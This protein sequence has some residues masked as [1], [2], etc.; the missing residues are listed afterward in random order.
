[1][2][3]IQLAACFGTAL[4]LFKILIIYLGD[5]SPWYTRISFILFSFTYIFF[6]SLAVY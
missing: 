2:Y 4:Y 1:M 5:L 3:L 6:S